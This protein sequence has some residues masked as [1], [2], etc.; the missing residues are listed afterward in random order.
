MTQ[1]I[2]SVIAALQAEGIAA[3]PALSAD[4]R[5]EPETVFAAVGLQQA[6]CGS[7][8]YLGPD[9]QGRER[10]VQT[11]SAQLFADVFT[12]L[13]GGGQQN[14]RA[15]EQVCMALMRGVPGLSIRQ[16]EAGRCRYDENAGCFVSTVCVQAT[17]TIH[18]VSP[19]QAAELQQIR[20]LPE[21]KGAMQ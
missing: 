4:E 9:A 20:L 3:G 11:I 19:T 21:Q 12:P 8:V 18:A 10:Y 15:V 2:E 17:G 7:T 16:T 5:T 1:L 14:T 13:A 6:V